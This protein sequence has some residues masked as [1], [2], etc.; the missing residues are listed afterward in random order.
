MKKPV[1]TTAG[2]V[3]TIIMTRGILIAGNESALIN[4]IEDETARRVKRY[5]ITLI[6]D[7]FSTD[8]VKP[9][10]QP[11]HESPSPDSAADS[12]KKGRN[13]LDWNPGSAISAR[14][15]VIA[16]ENRLGR[17]DEAILVCYPPSACYALAD[18]GLADV[19]VMVNE[20]IK[21]WFFLVKELTAVFKARGEGTLAL[22]Y[23]ETGGKDGAE[24]LGQAALAAFR[25]FT[26]GLLSVASDEPYLTMGFGGADD[27]K[28]FAAFIF[29]QLEEGNRRSNGKLHKYGKL[30]FFR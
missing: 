26:H 9:G 4:A 10:N 16:A 27:E 18:L 12:L 19:E 22:V 30:G 5:A 7:R 29:K 11:R 17:I 8:E 2:R 23:P 15:L 28:G 24:L 25:S 3:Y 6:Q 20:H 21:G 14:T 13:L 1:A